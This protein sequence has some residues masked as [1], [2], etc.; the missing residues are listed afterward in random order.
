ME[1]LA[2]SNDQSFDI[3]RMTAGQA[4]KP[5]INANECVNSERT[6]DVPLADLLSRTKVQERLPTI[7]YLDCSQVSLNVRRCPETRCGYGIGI[8]G[9]DL[10]VLVDAHGGLVLQRKLL[11][12]RYSCEVLHSR[13]G[14]RGRVSLMLGWV[15][16]STGEVERQ[17]TRIK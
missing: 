2:I 12:Q 14:I 6:N 15:V 8:Y 16:S 13:C 9:E 4:I 3:E 17:D 7:T 10:V 5:V 11:Y 1:S